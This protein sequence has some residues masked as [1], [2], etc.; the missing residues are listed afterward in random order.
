MKMAVDDHAGPFMTAETFLASPFL[1]SANGRIYRTGDLARYRPNGNIELVG[2]VDNQVK[3]RGYRIEL[4]EIENRLLEWEEV[5]QL[6][7][8]NS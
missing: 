4:G 5:A 6:I 8:T 1:P 3:I 2:R 7:E